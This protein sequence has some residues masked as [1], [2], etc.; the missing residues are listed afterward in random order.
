VSRATD[1]SHR[2]TVFIHLQLGTSTMLPIGELFELECETYVTSVLSTS[3]KLEN[4]QFQDASG[5]DQCLASKIVPDTGAQFILNQACG[6]TALAEVLG[7]SI[8]ILDGVSPNPSSGHIQMT[9][10]VPPGN[11]NDALLEIYNDLGEELGQQPIVFSAG[12]S[13][14]QSIPVDLPVGITKTNDGIL[15]LRIRTQS[16]FLTARV[17]LLSVP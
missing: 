13:G 10:T 1:G 16:G 5:S 4:V 12:T 15:Y 9:F 14:M 8:L 7:S 11:A 17:I 2:D 6:D 3:I